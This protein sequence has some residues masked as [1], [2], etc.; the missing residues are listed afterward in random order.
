MGAVYRGLDTRLNRPVAIKILSGTGNSGPRQR[1]LQEARAASALNHPHI[2]HVYDIGSTDDTDYI[3]MEFVDGETL[4]DAIAGKGLPL[5]SVLEQAIQIADALATA[6]AAGIVH[7]DV[8]PSNVRINSKSVVKVLDFGLAKLVQVGSAGESASTRTLQPETAEGTILGTFAY[9]SPEQ[10]QGQPVDHRADIFSFGALLYEMVAGQRVFQRESTVATL[11]AI[12][13]DDPPPLR[14]VVKSAPYDLERIVT[15][16]LR[17]DPE[18][19][20]QHMDDVKVAL[21]EVRDQVASGAA[22]AAPETRRRHTLRWVAATVLPVILL[23]LV[24]WRL[25]S[26]R[27]VLRAVELTR[28]TSDAGLTEHPALSRD[29]RLLAYVSDRDGGVLHI[30]V[31]QVGG[32]DPVRVTSGPADDTEPSFSPDGTLIAFRSQRDGGGIYVAPA[33]GGMPRRITDQGRG[34]RFSPDGQW[35]AYWVGDFGIFSRNSMYIVPSTGGETRRIAHG[36]YSAYHPLWSA[37]GRHLLF[38]GA[39][40]D[41]KSVADR[42]EWWVAPL[43]RGTP[44]ATGALAAL[45]EMGVF[46]VLR[47]PLGDWVGDSIVF[48]ATTAG[49]AKVI[50]TGRN[51]Q[52]SIWSLRLDPHS[53]RMSDKPRQITLGAGVESQPSMAL[54]AQGSARLAL[55][56]TSKNPEIWALPVDANRG[57]VT[58]EMRR[59]TTTVASNG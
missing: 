7:R 43:D 37:D 51:N 48:A 57:K 53:W 24:A 55:A 27:P 21:R 14:T 28:V 52:S 39:A 50:S 10:A 9:M 1:F 5:K 30:W 17:K 18:Y 13:R 45:R 22:A 20:F 26:R 44:V 3:V 11:S 36:F 29:G 6:H 32:G 42:Y 4:H 31:Q 15:R 40:D 23:S 8:K 46:A 59:L 12:L 58:G 35:L 33:L 19:R 34:P 47:E 2:V 38:V 41:K 16:C 56:T 54:P 25:F 49:Y